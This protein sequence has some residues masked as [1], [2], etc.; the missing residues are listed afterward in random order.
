VPSPRCGRTSPRAQPGT[1]ATYRA[2]L[3]GA[4]IF[5]RDRGL[6]Q[7]ASPAFI[8]DFPLGSPTG[9]SFGE[10]S[11]ASTS[12]TSCKERSVADRPAHVTDL[13]CHQSLQLHDEICPDRADIWLRYQ[14]CVAHGLALWLATAASNRQRPEVSLALDERC[15]TTFG[16]L[17]T[18]HAVEQLTAGRR[19]GSGLFDI[20][21]K[22][23]PDLSSAISVHATRADVGCSGVLR[24]AYRTKNWFTS[25][26]NWVWCWNR[27]P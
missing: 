10:A 5:Y 11:I 26:A 24:H 19:P 9:R 13:V 14:A 3:I 25:A 6:T 8:R 7:P 27:K 1:A 17:D 20:F 18:P 23:R 4:T 22:G 2:L 15:A 12:G 16:D 21:R